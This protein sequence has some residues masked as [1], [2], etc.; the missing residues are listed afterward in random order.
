MA[1]QVYQ[2]ETEY[3]QA[4]YSQCGTVLKVRACRDPRMH[5]VGSLT[6]APSAARGVC[7]G[8]D[9]GAQGFEGFLSSK[10]ALRKRARAFKPEDR[11]FSLSSCSSMAVC[12]PSLACKQPDH[13]A[14]A[15]RADMSG[16]CA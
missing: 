11:S 9:A 16:P 10:D 7:H 14:H 2:M 4:E 15:A 5:A 13:A 1:L 12:A 8:R 6:R 3:L